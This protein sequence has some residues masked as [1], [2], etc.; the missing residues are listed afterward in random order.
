MEFFVVE[1]RLMA[2]SS[3]VPLVAFTFYRPRR[4]KGF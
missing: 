3:V 2:E 4:L 1:D